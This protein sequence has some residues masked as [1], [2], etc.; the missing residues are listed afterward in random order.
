MKQRVEFAFDSATLLPLSFA[1]LDEVIDILHKHPALQI[2]VEGHTCSIGT[3]EYNLELSQARARTVVDYLIQK[4][5][6]RGRLTPVG[7]GLS[8]PL[9]D[10]T[11]EEGRVKNRRV[12][13]EIVP[14]GQASR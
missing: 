5:I 9:T 14:I 8:R 13:F 6:D 11:S 1:I 4:G 3:D 10:N 12:Q 2:R 7:F